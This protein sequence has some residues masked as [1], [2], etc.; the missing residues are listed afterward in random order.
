MFRVQ[1]KPVPVIAAC[2]LLIQAEVKKQAIGCRASAMDLDRDIGVMRQE[3]KRDTELH[4]GAV[5]VAHAALALSEAPTADAV[6]AVVERFEPEKLLADCR[7]APKALEEGHSGID[8]Y[9]SKEELD[10]R[11]NQAEKSLIKPL[12]VLEF[13]RVIWSLEN[14]STRSQPDAVALHA[15]SPSKPSGLLSLRNPDAS[16][17]WATRIVV[18]GIDTHDSL[19]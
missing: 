1:Y 5:I 2:C 13:Y 19:L 15:G 9:T 4:G 7:I 11:F 3:R 10:R 18:C 6:D 14:S 16:C 12:S 8:R 17:V